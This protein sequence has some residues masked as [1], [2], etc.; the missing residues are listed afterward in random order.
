MTKVLQLTEPSEGLKT[1]GH[2]SCD[3]PALLCRNTHKKIPKLLL[4]SLK[5]SEFSPGSPQHSPVMFPG[6]LSG[7][8][9]DSGIPGPTSPFPAPHPHPGSNASASLLVGGT[10]PYHFRH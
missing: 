1:P 6:L 5:N 7:R 10:C 8:Q 9:L 3:L 4:L 2:N